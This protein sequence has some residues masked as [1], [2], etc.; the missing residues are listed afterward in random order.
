MMVGSAGGTVA[1][2]FKEYLNTPNSWQ[3][4]DRLA[5]WGTPDS[6]VGNNGRY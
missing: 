5:S 6:V 3:R 4:I 2:S 1:L